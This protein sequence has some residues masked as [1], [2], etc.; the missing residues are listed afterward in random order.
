MTRRAVV[1]FSAGL[2]VALA[3]G[4]LG[5]PRLLYARAGGVL[6]GYLAIRFMRLESGMEA[7][8]IV[9]VLASDAAAEH[10]LLASAPAHA[11]HARAVELTFTRIGKV[12]PTLPYSSVTQDTGRIAFVRA[13]QPEAVGSLMPPLP[14]WRFTFADSDAD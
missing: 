13:L 9:D 10:A 12:A 5:F 7:A 14:D 3:L 11:A 4:W 6:R 1:L 2:A 8:A